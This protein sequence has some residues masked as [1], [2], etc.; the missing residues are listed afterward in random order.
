MADSADAPHDSHAGASRA[1]RRGA[2]ISAVGE[3]GVLL[4]GFVASILIARYLGPADRGLLAIIQVVATIGVSLLGLG[5]PVAAQ[6]QAAR[7]TRLTGTLIGNC[8]V[9]G[10]VL[11]VVAVVSAAVL[12]VVGPDLV[13]SPP[14]NTVWFL[15]AGLVPLTLIDYLTSGL[16][17]AHRRFKRQTTLI[18]LG[19]C[20]TVVMAIVLLVAT[21]TGLAG[22][23]VATMSAQMV[24]VIGGLVVLVRGGVG[25][26]RPLLMASYRYGI[27]SE[28]GSLLQLA[29]ARLDLL[30]LSAFA[31][32]STVGIYAI[33]Q[34]VAELVGV[35]PN[36]ISTA[37]MPV[38]SSGDGDSRTSAGALRLNGTGSLIGVLGVAVG[39]PILIL[40][41]YGDSYRDAVLPMLILL[42]GIWFLS[43]A[44]VGGW[45]LRA[46]GR[47]GL[48][49]SLA[50]AEIVVMISAD[51]LLIPPFGA[52]GAAA[53]SAVA[54][55]FYGVAMLVTVSRIEQTPIR[56]LL[57]LDRGE[58]AAA[59]GKVRSL[60]RRSG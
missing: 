23:L 20:A 7:D 49:S 37:V 32:R 9:I 22:A 36:A 40:G 25:V 6:Y 4:V 5:L 8:L 3:V 18:I 10:A 53:A 19:R 52:N 34:I 43:A 29:N 2:A 1:L 57:L 33:A 58:R 48:G 15:A 17:A 59:L 27:R 45:L 42:P 12:V 60:L 51:L 31:S 21:D 55:A 35:V 26:S 50:A 39:G 11:A 47:P 54:Y 24:M 38:L 56:H 30:V 44:R 13:D 14:S 41:A 28:I 16:L 46:R